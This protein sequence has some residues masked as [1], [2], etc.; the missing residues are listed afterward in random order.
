MNGSGDSIARNCTVSRGDS[1]PV[2]M[3]ITMPDTNALSSPHRPLWLS[4][5]PLRIDWPIRVQP[6]TMSMMPCMGLA[7]GCHAVP[8]AS[9]VIG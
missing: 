7:S 8:D 1:V 9:R 3:P 5:T 2:A 4:K 6:P